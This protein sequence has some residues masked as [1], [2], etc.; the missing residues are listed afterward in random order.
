MKNTLILLCLLFV[1][2]SANAQLM[3]R[4]FLANANFYNGRLEDKNIDSLSGFGKITTVVNRQLSGRCFFEPEC[5]L[6]FEEAVHRF[7]LFPAIFITA[8]RMTRCSRIGAAGMPSFYFESEDGKFHEGT[9]AYILSRIKTV[10]P[11]STDSFPVSVNTLRGFDVEKKTLRNASADYDFVHYLI[12]NE[13]KEDA[14]FLLGRDDYYAKSDTLYYLRGWTSYS[15][16]RLEEASES[17]GLVPADSHLFLKSSFFNMISNVHLGKYGIADT[18]L[19]G[20]SASVGEKYSELYYLEKGGVAMLNNDADG[21]LQCSSHFTYSDYNLAESEKNL[22]FLYKNKFEGRSKSP[23][24]AGVASAIIP[25]LGKIYAG[26]TTEGIASF[27]VVGSFA[28]VTAENW[29]KN[30]L[31]NWKTILFGL[32]GATFYI[33]NIYGSVISVQTYNNDIR[34]KQDTSIMYSIHIPLR[35]AFD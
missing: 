22:D 34:K 31:E 5:N 32:I 3:D 30:G 12:G 15:L 8:D 24:I 19:S 18:I 11:L 9:D 27:L 20:I 28:A 4:E 21:Y 23:F 7:T 13:M 16:K 10:F 2:F 14:L 29:I 1:A 26:K 6:F 17:F 25:G 35:S 33:G